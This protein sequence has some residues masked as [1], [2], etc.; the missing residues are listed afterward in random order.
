VTVSGLPWPA[1]NGGK[2]FECDQCG[3][4]FDT[5]TGIAIHQVYGCNSQR[6][7]APVANKTLPS[8]PA[9]GSFALYCER[10]GKLTCQTCTRSS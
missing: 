7:P 1:Y 5:S 8:C 9:C 3:R 2:Q 4:R 6:I 10:D